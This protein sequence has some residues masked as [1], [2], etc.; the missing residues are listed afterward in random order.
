[1]GLSVAVFA[2]C[3]LP[4]EDGGFGEDFEE[5]VLGFVVTEVAESMGSGFVGVVVAGARADEFDHTG[6][7]ELMGGSDVSSDFSTSSSLAGFLGADAECTI[8]SFTAHAI[9]LRCHVWFKGL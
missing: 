6:A 8:N 9:S 5:A 4:A 1:M 3:S 2:D 7:T